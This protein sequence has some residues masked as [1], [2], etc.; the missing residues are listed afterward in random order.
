MDGLWTKDGQRT[1]AQGPRTTCY[2][3]SKNAVVPNSYSAAAFFRVRRAAGLAAVFA[4]RGAR[5]VDPPDDL[6]VRERALGAAR[7][8]SSAVVSIATIGWLSLASSSGSSA[9]GGGSIGCCCGAVI[10]LVSIGTG[11]ISIERC[12]SV[13]TSP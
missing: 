6:A 2:T 9:G 7:P 13:T 10:I 4:A 3:D 12:A 8:R 5:V 1:L 11:T